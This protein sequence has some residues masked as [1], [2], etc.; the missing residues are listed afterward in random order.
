MARNNCFAARPHPQLHDCLA[1]VVSPVVLGVLSPAGVNAL[2]GLIVCACVATLN[3]AVPDDNLTRIVFLSIQNGERLD[4]H[5][6]MPSPW[7]VPTT[8]PVVSHD[9]TRVDIADANGAQDVLS[10]LEPFLGIAH[11]SIPVFAEVNAALT[12]LYTLKTSTST[13]NVMPVNFS[14]LRREFG[15]FV[16][17]G[18]TDDV[19]VGILNELCATLEAMDTKPEDARANRP[20]IVDPNVIA[21]KG[22]LAT[23]TSSKV[24][25]TSKQP[26]TKTVSDYQIAALGRERKP[27]TS[28]RHVCPI[29]CREGHHA[30][31][32]RDVLLDE[33]AER[34]DGFFKR[35][36]EGNATE[37]YARAMSA[38][39]SAEFATAIAARIRAVSASMQGVSA[40][41]SGGSA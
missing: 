9:I 23:N 36:I 25:M 4:K 27:K 24:D 16:M 20:S 21:M 34:A 32:C 38:R 28:R 3:D 35:L 5:S 37:P 29:C 1:M 11:R 6:W 17:L 10:R 15:Q 12:T 30:K 41:P 18:E 13:Q 22:R 7:I 26:G 39:V 2:I 8:Q 14:F 40:T 33:H 19:V 31:T